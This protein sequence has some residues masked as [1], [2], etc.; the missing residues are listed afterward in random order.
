MPRARQLVILTACLAVLV[1]ST[2]RA[3]AQEGTA[4]AAGQLSRGHRWIRSHRFVISALTQNEPLF[5]VDEYRGAGLNTLM[6]WDPKLTL[7]KKASAARLPIHYH[8]HQNNGKN[9]AEYVAHLRKLWAAYPTSDGVL[10][11]D[12]PRVPA[13]KQ[14]GE[15]CD[16]L[17][18]AFPGTLVYSNA[19]PKGN[20]RPA[21]YGL[22]ADTKGD[23]YAT[24]LERFATE[25]RGDVLMI[26]I[27]P[28]GPGG[29]HSRVYYETLLLVRHL[30][31]KHGVPYWLFIQ[32]Y[33]HDGRLRS[34][35]ESDLRFQLYTP[36]A[37]GFTGISYFSY[38][39]AI[40]SGL[41]NA[42]KERQPIY[43][44][45]SDVNQEVV[46]VGRALRYL[47][48]TGVAFV[49]GQHEENGKSVPNAM[50]STPEGGSYQWPAAGGRPA[51]LRGARVVESG[52]GRNALLGFYRDDAGGDYLMVTNLWHDKGLSAAAANGTVQLMLDPSILSVARLSRETGSVEQ[53]VVTNGTLTITL[54]GGTGDL[55]KIKDGRFPGLSEKRP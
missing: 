36:L 25:V 22:P 44:L 52:R 50:P 11:Y 27:Y 20:P 35:S 55:L 14:V 3:T 18:K 13:M 49:L 24:Y 19:M 7:F 38:G 34:P 29:G 39:P 53:L 4:T 30:G 17:R 8:M 28:L 32:G 54:P 41:I 2:E 40:G 42:K 15:V 10:F 45:A 1:P 46:H 12:E 37:M 31:L 9:V 6:A 48:S 5:D 21:K 51:W 26:D 43:Y 33:N 16:A 23:F 47:K